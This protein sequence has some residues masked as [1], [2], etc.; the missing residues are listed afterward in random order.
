MKNPIVDRVGAGVGI[1]E[2]VGAKDGSA[3]VGE[4]DGAGVVGDHVVVVG[5]FVGVAVGA[6]VIDGATVVS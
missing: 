3:V 2:I 1:G 5:A 6:A 4:R